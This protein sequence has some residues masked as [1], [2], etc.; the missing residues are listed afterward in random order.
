[1]ISLMNDNL[2]KKDPDLEDGTGQ[3][4]AEDETL[5]ELRHLLIS[6]VESQV[7]EIQTRLDDPE[8]R[9]REVGNI[10]P[11]AIRVR[12]AQDDAL[13]MSLSAT[14]EQ[15]LRF[16]IRNNLKSLADTLFPVIGPA[17]RKAISEALRGMIQSLNEAMDQS[18][19]IKGLKWRF[20]AYRA[21]KPFSE[22]VLLHSIIYRVEQVFL[23]HKKTGLLLKHVVKEEL[24]FQD[25]DMVSGMLTA[26]RDFV[27]DSFN[28]EEGEGLESIL[29]GELNV[30]IEHGPDAILAVVIRG[31]A[32]A[33]LRA[34][35]KE[36]LE[37]IHVEFG[38]ALERY[39]GDTSQFEATTHI[40]ESCIVSRYIEDKKK[41]SPILIASITG[42]ACLAL[43]WGW[44]SLKEYWRWQDL[45]VRLNSTPGIVITQA[46][47]DDGIYIVRGLRDNLSENPAE[48][49]AHAGMNPEGVNFYWTPYQ[50]LSD[51]IVL[52]RAEESLRPGAGVTLS[53]KQGVLSARGKTD[54][55]WLRQAQDRVRSIAGVNQFDTASLTIE[56]KA[57]Y[58]AFMDF[59]QKLK[60]E[61]GIVITSYGSEKGKYSV[62]GLLDPFAVD[63][64]SLL[65]ATGLNVSDITFNWEP[66]QSGDIH[67]ILK[68]IQK[69]LNPPATLK[70]GVVGNCISISGAASNDWLLELKGWL[71]AIPTAPCLD[72]KR[73][74][75]L[76]YQEMINLKG[77]IESQGI[78]FKSDSSVSV[79][80]Q[81]EKMEKLAGE[82][83]RLVELSKKLK[84]PVQISIY[85]HTDRS[86]TEER[87][88]ALSQERAQRMLE[89]LISRGVPV[90]LFS[91]EALGSTKPVSSE[92]TEPG[93]EVNRRVS[94]E[95]N[96][97]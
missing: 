86:G 46:Y 69:L 29:V 87:N 94:F 3:I 21:K 78:L 44:F 71:K 64:K 32:P 9:S 50:A 49:A 45:L 72:L 54:L 76:D 35:M 6:P 92:H 20:E 19:S 58:E 93:L 56:D 70:M 65:P 39:D 51:E 11:Q 74:V 53:I 81:F 7:D 4:T 33:S 66:Y 43:I 59:L 67:I 26:I 10:L 17:I 52:K 14:M 41:T 73:F 30:W 5:V 61:K 85:G 95:V 13:A 24:E 82:M 80:G 47:K 79:K 42:V 15:A 12:A 91:L 28:V 75:N 48:I 18:F 96:F 38:E 40:L 68:R 8:L 62:S 27:A 84:I 16:S 23:I 25:A 22:I 31:N 2:E 77:D 1:M 97:R 63:P 57:G 83:R 34:V 89:F 55:E 37:K 36:A 88:R 90:E 60:A